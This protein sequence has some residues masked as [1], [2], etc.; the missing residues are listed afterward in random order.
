MNIEVL[1]INMIK[2]VKEKRMGRYLKRT[3]THVHTHI[4]TQ[5]QRHTHTCNC[6]INRLDANSSSV[7][8]RDLS[9]SCWAKRASYS[10]RISPGWHTWG[11]GTLV[12][13]HKDKKYISQWCLCITTRNIY[14]NG[15]MCKE[16][17]Y[18]SQWFLC[19]NYSYSKYQILE[20]NT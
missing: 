15:V 18:I 11:F 16:K 8:C 4:H 7:L 17:P 5:T 3:H 6:C 9:C 10:C 20:I 13:K 1:I 2:N 19:V 12:S 14:Y